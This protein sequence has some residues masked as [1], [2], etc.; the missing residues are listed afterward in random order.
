LDNRAL[1]KDSDFERADVDFRTNSRL[2]RKI[3]SSAEPKRSNDR[4]FSLRVS[5]EIAQAFPLQPVELV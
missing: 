2:A 5:R 1:V 4:D 3:P